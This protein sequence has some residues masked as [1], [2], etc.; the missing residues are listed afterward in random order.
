MGWG[1][2]YHDHVKEAAEAIRED[3]RLERRHK[4][5]KQS[6]V[7]W[8]SGCSHMPKVSRDLCAVCYGIYRKCNK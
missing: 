1:W 7:G 8:V 3:E 6:R 4:M 5:F 2:D